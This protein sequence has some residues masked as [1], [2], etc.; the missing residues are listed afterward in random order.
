MIVINT[1]EV[2]IDDSH[3]Q[4]RYRLIIGINTAEVP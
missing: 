3:L 1:A 4:Q 2:S